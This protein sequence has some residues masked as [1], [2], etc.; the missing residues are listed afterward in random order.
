M[1]LF[2]FEKE[3]HIIENLLLEKEV[4]Q[5]YT[6]Q[7]WYEYFVKIYGKKHTNLHLYA[8]YSLICLIAHIYIAK[9]ILEQEVDFN[10][11]QFLS[12]LITNLSNLVKE[13]YDFEVSGALY[14]FVPFFKILEYSEFK[15]IEDLVKIVISSMNSLNTTPEYIFDVLVQKLLSPYVRHKSGEFYTP[16]FIVKKMV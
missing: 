1:G 8:I 13:N 10:S 14:Y 5:S 12:K 7:E 2:P 6:Y 15:K 9:Y 3:L 11:K 4:E 16:P